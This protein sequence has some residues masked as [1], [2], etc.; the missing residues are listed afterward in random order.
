MINQT[1]RKQFTVCVVLFVLLR[2]NFHHDQSEAK[3]GPSLASDW[4]SPT[5]WPSPCEWVTSVSG[6]LLWVGHFCEWM[7]SVGESRLWVGHFCESFCESFLWVGHLVAECHQPSA[8]A[9]M[10]VPV[11][12]CPFLG[13]CVSPH[14]YS[15]PNYKMPTRYSQASCLM[16]SMMS[17]IETECV[18]NAIA[19]VAPFTRASPSL[20]A[21][22]PAKC[23]VHR[24]DYC[25]EK[26]SA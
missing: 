21:P 14:Y 22:I 3:L 5:D 2:H 7:T 12:S 11:R 23:C 6:S 10:V 25:Q 16:A 24:G 18:C 9:R 17:S 13:K 26:I 19:G 20:D 1:L 4:P 15:N 8:G